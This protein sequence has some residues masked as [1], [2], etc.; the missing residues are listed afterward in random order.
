MT[1]RMTVFILLILIAGHASTGRGSDSAIYR[2]TDQNGG[3]HFS[4]KRPPNSNAEKLATPEPQVISVPDLPPVTDAE[5]PEPKPPR[6]NP[7]P[8][9]SPVTCAR[10]NIE[11]DTL[12]RAEAVFR[13]AEG[14]F[15]THRSRFSRY[16]QGR[17]D[18]LDDDSRK[19]LISRLQTRL[20]RQC[21]PSPEAMRAVSIEQ[22]NLARRRDCALFT[23]YYQEQASSKY[24]LPDSELKSLEALRNRMCRGPD[25]N[26]ALK[27]AP[28]D[29][30]RRM[31][32]R[33]E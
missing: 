26:G 13:D 11:L 14:H 30:N 32:G 5:T 4:D 15:H 18:Y 7:H 3:T 33:H 1:R 27:S 25:E 9:A 12:K 20:K 2:W 16:Y 19:T 8:Y 24:R 23:T 17:R 22:A 6:R 31:S 28:D 10:I 21:D 29:S